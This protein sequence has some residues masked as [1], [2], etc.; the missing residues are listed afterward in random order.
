MKKKFADFSEEKNIIVKNYQRIDINDK[1]CA[2]A[3]L[4][5]IE[6]IKDKV[7]V[8]INGEA[9]TI[10]DIG[11]RIITLYPQDENFVIQAIYNNK[12]EFV[13][14]Y[15]DIACKTKYT[16]KVPFIEDLYLDI[17]I[18]DKDEIVFIDEDVLDNA[19]KSKKLKQNDY[20]LA[21]RTADKIVH[22]F[23]SEEQIKK[24]EE[25]CKMY[26]EKVLNI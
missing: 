24:L 14:F 2:V 15:F 16:A 13:G 4:E 7:S 18:S 19:F 6:N 1:C 3:C 11:Y 10:I 22:K 25:T 26:M 8:N 23:H 12:L 17:F 9:R 20:D 5:D 21:K